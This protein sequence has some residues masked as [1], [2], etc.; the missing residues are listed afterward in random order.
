MKP[1][2]DVIKTASLESS[3]LTEKLKK[4]Y[5]KCAETLQ[6]ISKSKTP[7]SKMKVIM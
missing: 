2:T 6:K 5:R 7:T 1:S 4:P 3:K